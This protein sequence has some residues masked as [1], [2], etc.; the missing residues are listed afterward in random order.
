MLAL[1]PPLADT[2]G[3][4]GAA[5]DIAAETLLLLLPPYSTVPGKL[6]LRWYPGRAAALSECMALAA[7]VTGTGAAADVQLCALVLAEYVPGGLSLS[8]GA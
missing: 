2:C 7:G 1:Y 3:R 6:A 5:G 8:P 4:L